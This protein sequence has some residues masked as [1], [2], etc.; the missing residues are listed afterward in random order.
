MLYD[1]GSEQV[2]L[3]LMPTEARMIHNRLFLLTCSAH[4]VRA[5]LVM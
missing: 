2:P 4:L 3:L 1:C 5:E